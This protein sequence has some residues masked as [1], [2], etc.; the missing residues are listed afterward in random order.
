[1]C[2]FRPTF[3]FM[4]AFRF[5]CQVSIKT[6]PDRFGFSRFESLKIVYLIRSGWN[7]ASFASF[8]N[9]SVEEDKRRK[10]GEEVETRPAI[11]WLSAM[12]QSIWLQ[13]IPFNWI[14][15]CRKNYPTTTS[16]R[17]CTTLPLVL[18]YLLGYPSDLKLQSGYYGFDR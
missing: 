11:R 9:S 4:A 15:T 1:M 13:G 18:S 5:L 14:M 16:K 6:D 2:R 10:P 3:L 12:Q 17:F 7:R 8:S